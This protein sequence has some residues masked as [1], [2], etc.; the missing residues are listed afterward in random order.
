[1]LLEVTGIVFRKLGSVAQTFLVA[2]DCSAVAW[3]R[4]VHEVGYVT[5]VWRYFRISY[6][7]CE[8]ND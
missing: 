1:M 4:T 7:K 2:V 8:S 6:E 5:S 3:I